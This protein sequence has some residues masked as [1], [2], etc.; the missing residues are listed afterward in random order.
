MTPDCRFNPAPS[1]HSR[2]NG[3]ICQRRRS[4]AM[5]NRLLDDRELLLFTDLKQ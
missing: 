4:A 5:K 1:F 2:P 3:T